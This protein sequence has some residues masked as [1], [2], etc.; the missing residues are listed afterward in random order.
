MNHFRYRISWGKSQKYVN[1]ILSNLHNIYL[2]LITGRYLP[3]TLLHKILYV[4]PQDPFTI[5]R[6]PYQ[7]ISGVIY[8]MTR[9]F[10]SHT[11][12]LDHFNT[13]LKDNVSSPP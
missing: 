3:E 1:M 12:I 11:N 5:L 7:M 4:I 9:T 6:S 13:F 2:I 10:Y 8:G